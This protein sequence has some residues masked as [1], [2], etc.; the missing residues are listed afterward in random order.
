MNNLEFTRFETLNYACEEALNTLCTN[1]TFAGKDKKVLMV[2]SSQ[3]HEGKSFVSMNAMR[4]FASLGYRVALVDTD[5]RKSQISAKYGMR[6][7]EGQGYGLAHYLA[8]MCT[9]ENVLYETNIPNAYMVPI[10]RSV[11][12]SLSLLTSDRLETLIEALREKFDYVIV[13]APPIGIIIDA[14]QIAK[15]SDGVLIAVKYNSIGR[16]ELAGV[17]DQVEKTGCPILGC[18]L[19][20][21]T[22]DSISSKHYYNRYYYY[23]Y[24]SGYYAYDA[25]GKKRKMK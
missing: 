9:M 11:S 3:P 15:F 20:S 2:T 1:L 23:H 14:A 22:F 17:K 13:D 5:L 12:Y 7:T 21:V 18:V 10:G 25:K 4:T 24:N 6:V 16:R 8:G 19:N